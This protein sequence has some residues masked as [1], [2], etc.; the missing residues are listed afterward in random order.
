[1]FKG[2]L[3]A[4]AEY[5]IKNTKNSVTQITLA[6][7][8]G[9][10]SFPEN[11]GTLEN[12]GV[13]LNLAVIPYRNDAAQS[14]WV[15][16]VN[17]SHNT[18]KL[19]KISDALRRQNELN[20]SAESISPLPRY[21]EGMSTT[22][23]WAVK[24]LGI[25]PATGDEILL[26]RNGSI[27]SEYDVVDAVV[28]GDTEPKW[29][30]TINTAFQYKGFGANL[31]FT[32]RFGGQ[33][34]NETLVSKV[35]NADLRYNADRRVLTERWQKPGDR[36]QYKRLTNSADGA[37]TQQTSRFVM[38]EN[39]L[40]MGSL[41]LTYRMDS[42]NAP[43]LKKLRISSMKWGFTMEDVFYASTIKRERGT[44]Y[45]FSRQFALSLNLV[46]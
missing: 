4:R 30:G 26:K 46:F 18:N 24:S 41:S 43:W 21:V 5:Y 27:T 39:T 22:A 2:R 40:Q 13:E 7:S 16:S 33:M 20:A 32:Y 8:L 38:D 25:D 6:P 42:N 44:I 37:N 17:G 15:V 9:F 29:Q 19:T 28:C 10:S 34:Y 12:R 36:A 14:Y 23:I 3:T 35:E 1:M 31:S 45:P 11:M